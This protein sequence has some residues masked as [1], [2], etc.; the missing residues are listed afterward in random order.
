MGANFSLGKCK[1]RAGFSAKLHNSRKLN[2]QRI[3]GHFE[4]ILE[5]PLLAVIKVSGVEIIVH[6]YGELHFKKCQDTKLMDQIAEEIYSVG[7]KK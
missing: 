3:N 4:T 1:T 6:G 7:L 2:L 5:T